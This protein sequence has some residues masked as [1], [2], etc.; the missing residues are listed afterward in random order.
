M[1]ADVA[2][3]NLFEGLKERRD[4]LLTCWGQ[5]IKSLVAS[6]SLPRAELLDHMPAFVDEVIQALYP[7]AVPLPPMSARAEQ[8]GEQRLGLG[9]DVAEVVREYGMLHDCILDVAAEAGLDI[10]RRDQGV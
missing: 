8:H 3:K 4:H 2:R 7:G 5:R 10:D 1:A 6:A 9:F